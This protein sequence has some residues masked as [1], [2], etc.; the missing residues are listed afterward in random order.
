MLGSNEN[1]DIISPVFSFP[2]TNPS[3]LQFL[4][5]S[6]W[7]LAKG[8]SISSHLLHF[9]YTLWFVHPIHSYK[10]FLTIL[11]L[12]YTL[13]FLQ[14]HLGIYWISQI[15]DFPWA[16]LHFPQITIDPISHAGGSK[17]LVFHSLQP[18]S[19]L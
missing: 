2:S 5:S 17:G 15:T 9:F 16:N 10:H 18:H 14:L 12:L 8:L 11:G 3:G 13:H 7:I 1:E 6:R 19:S 4:L